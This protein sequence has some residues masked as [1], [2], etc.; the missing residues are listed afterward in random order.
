MDARNRT[1]LLLALL[2]GTS[3]LAAS[4][5]AEWCHFLLV[6][7]P[8]GE[9]FQR[10]FSEMR[11]GGLHGEIGKAGLWSGAGVCIGMFM[12]MSRQLSRRTRIAVACATAVGITG[13]CVSGTVRTIGGIAVGA[14][15]S[16]ICIATATAGRRPM[17]ASIAVLTIAALLCMWWALDRRVEMDG[18]SSIVTMRSVAARMFWWSACWHGFE[19]HPLFGWG[20]GSTP[21]IVADYP[22]GPAFAAA[23]PAVVD[24][25]P[26]LLSPSQPHSLYIM[27]LAELGIIGIALLGAI[28]CM[29]ARVTAR[30]ARLGVAHAGAA[31]ATILWIVSAAGDTVF[32]SSVLAAGGIVM[33]LMWPHT[34]A[35]VD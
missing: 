1:T 21:A 29:I 24:L 33:A 2:V 31:A 13:V 7:V 6:M 34:Q 22:H 25:H 32:N 35:E 30:S 28:L 26:T 5:I 4:Q 20:W 15:V 11:F 8:H 18:A 10:V 16:A 14:C 12:C 9:E 23:N 3:V 27:V 19:Q 17:R